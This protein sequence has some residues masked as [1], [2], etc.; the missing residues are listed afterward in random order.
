MAGLNGRTLLVMGKGR[1]QDKYLDILGTD[2]AQSILR[3][4]NPFKKGEDFTQLNCLV[5]GFE[6]KQGL[7]VCTA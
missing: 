7:A 1:L 6:V 4:L 2:L 3:L 5:N